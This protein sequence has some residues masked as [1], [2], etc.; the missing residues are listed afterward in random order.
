MNIH[1][2]YINEVMYNQFKNMMMFNTQMMKRAVERYNSIYGD[3]TK[4]G[5]SKNIQS[6]DIDVLTNISALVKE[7]SMLEV[8][9]EMARTT[10]DLEIEMISQSEYKR[11]YQD[12]AARRQAE[13]DKLKAAGKADYGNV[14]EVQEKYDAE[15]AALNERE[16]FETEEKTEEK[17]R[18]QDKQVS[19]KREE[20]TVYNEDGSV[21]GVFRAITHL[22]GS[23]EWQMKAGDM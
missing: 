20:F 12:I 15:E 10:E 11:L 3:L 6:K 16:I 2:E 19:T 1:Y 21:H 9:M 5:V 18:Y 17:P 14:S 23:V 4:S 7:M 22:D 8:E 13:L